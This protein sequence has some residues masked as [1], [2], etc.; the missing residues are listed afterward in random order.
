MFELLKRL[1]NRIA[2]MVNKE[3]MTDPEGTMMAETY[4]LIRERYTGDRGLYI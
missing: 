4:Q 2:H 1:S 3:N